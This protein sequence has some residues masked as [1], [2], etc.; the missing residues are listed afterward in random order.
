MAQLK[1]GTPANYSDGVNDKSGGRVERGMDDLP[2]HR[3]KIFLRAKW[4]PDHPVFTRTNFIETMFHADSLDFRLK[5]ANHQTALLKKSIIPNGNSCVIQRCIG[6]KTDT[7]RKAMVRIYADFLA[8]V[9]DFLVSR[10][11]NDFFEYNADGTLKKTTTAQIV[12]KIGFVAVP[13]TDSLVNGDFGAG[14]IIDGF[15][16][17]G[18]DVSKLYPIMDLEV[19]YYGSHGEN[20]GVRLWSWND[21]TSPGFDTTLLTDNSTASYPVNLAVYSRTDANSTPTPV[22]TVNG[23]SAVET[24]W[25]A[26][27]YHPKYPATVVSIYDQIVNAWRSKGEAGVPEFQYGFER[28]HIYTE[29]VKFLGAAIALTELTIKDIALDYKSED[30]TVEAFRS[31]ILGL[32]TTAGVEY[33]GTRFHTYAVTP[34]GYFKP[35][36]KTTVYAQGA[37]EQSFTNADYETEVRT[38]LAEYANVNSSMMDTARNVENVIWDSGF[39]L[40]TKLAFANFIAQRKDTFAFVA[41]HAAGE[42]L[43]TSQDSSMAST[44]QARFMSMPESDYFGT[45]VYR[46][47]VIGR[48]SELLDTN[49]R[50]A[51]EDTSTS[52]RRLP[53]TIE[54]AN[55]VSRAMG[56]SGGAWKKEVMFD[57]N[58]Y[59]VI[60]MLDPEKFNTTF[61]P[62]SVRNTDWTNGLNWVES[63]TLSSCFVPALQTVYDDDTSILNSVIT[64]LCACNLQWF[65]EHTWRV[66]VGRSGLT[67]EQFLARVGTYY[68]GLVE[69]KFAD[70]F[71]IV[72]KPYMTAD[73]LQRNYAWHLNVDLAGPGMKTAQR[74][75]LTTYRIED[76]T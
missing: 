38:Y 64:A 47:A 66:H 23:D 6:G 13:I 45:P 1:N 7:M 22:E 29:N 14:K 28:A 25:S 5:Y 59:N 24:V 49:Y 54:I 68:N 36:P 10:D 30:E 63:F 48:S 19:P 11:A 39:L 3:P 33:Q 42:K 62:V 18:A 16:T 58:P 75:S 71:T 44:L 56:A 27:T 52:K 40:N 69:G 53:T 37:D 35:G 76:Y 73:D 17:D 41:T 65:G 46:A 55:W 70:R 9:D 57:E 32:T 2:S 26:D 8:G 51:M 34:A 15:I 20:F 50:G 43:E 74:F 72:A 67:N 12:N 4:G 21:V 60:E 31:N 61:T